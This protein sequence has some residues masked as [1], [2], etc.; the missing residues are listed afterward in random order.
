MDFEKSIKRLQEIADLLNK[1]DLPLD[2]ATS[3]YEEGKNLSQECLNA[4]NE[5]KSK[6]SSLENRDA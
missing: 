3:L 1:G 5:A 4:I 2:Q 6:L